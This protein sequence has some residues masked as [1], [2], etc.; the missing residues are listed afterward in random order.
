MAGKGRAVQNGQDLRDAVAD[1][2]RSMGLE[3]EIEVQVGRRLWGARRRIDVVV[4][5]PET[6][7]TLGIECKY[8]ATQGTAQEKISATIEDMKGWPI[9]GIVVFDGDGFTSDMVAYL[10]STGKAIE[11]QDVRKWLELYF[12]L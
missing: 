12:G 7:R 10:L 9:R 6:R 8:Q 3:T 2:G 1:L 5:H 11:F 4:R